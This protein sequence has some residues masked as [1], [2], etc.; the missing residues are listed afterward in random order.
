MEINGVK[1]NGFDASGVKENFGTS[2][3]IDPMKVWALPK[4]KSHM[5]EELLNSEEYFKLVKK[6]GY[7]YQFEKNSEGTSAMFSRTI[8]KKTGY[9]LDK[10][11]NIPHIADVLDKKLPKGT[12]LIGETYLPGDRKSVV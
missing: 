6:D 10:S 5:K 7:W 2:L 4:N 8:S 12:I 9:Y 11:G 1:I 3:L